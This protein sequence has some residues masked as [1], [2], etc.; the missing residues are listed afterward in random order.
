MKIRSYHKFWQKIHESAK[1]KK[2]PLRAMFELTYRCN[3]K[4]PHCYIPFSY[5]KYGEL[6]TEE[7]F[8]ILDQLKGLGC[9]YLGFTGGEPFVREDIMDILWYAKRCGFEVI[10]YTNGSLINKRIAVE[11]QQLRPN[12]VDI[13]LPGISRE[14]F[15]KITGVAGSHKK[16]FRAIE[17]LNRNQVN[18]GFKSCLLKENEPEMSQIKR[19]AASLGALHRLDDMLS[20]RLDGSE[21]PFKYRAS[22]VEDRRNGIEKSKPSDYQGTEP[23]NCEYSS[24]KQQLDGISLFKCG[25]GQSQVAITPL[26]ELKMCLMI[27]WPKYKIST[28]N[29]SQNGN[30]KR[31]WNK[32]KKLVLDIEVDENYQ[33][34]K[35]KLESY[36]KW[37][38]A[39]SW[40]YNR[41]F[42]RCEPESQRQAE[43]RYRMVNPNGGEQCR[44]EVV[45]GS[46]RLKEI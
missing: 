14:V 34:D 42:T 41:T 4:C 8:S 39:K 40:L 9:F 46:G 18:L 23:L 20:A 19:F 38:P 3:F 5:R 33:C 16:T 27:D 24:D 28:D 17:L 37:C 7:I 26:G 15:E 12:K 35:C 11:L 36:C 31:V 30:L 29:K 45:I 1:E 6:K 44:K 2:F 25:V 43:Y 13:T 10:I 32:L 22:G 21:E